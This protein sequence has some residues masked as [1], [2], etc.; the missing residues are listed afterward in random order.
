MFK[1]LCGWTDGEKNFLPWM[2]QLKR[3]H[4]Q[5][6]VHRLVWML[7][8]YNSYIMKQQW[9]ISWILTVQLLSLLQSKRLVCVLISRLVTEI[10]V[11]FIRMG[12]CLCVLKFTTSL[13][14]IQHLVKSSYLSG[15]DMKYDLLSLSAI[16]KFLVM[17]DFLVDCSVVEEHFQNLEMN[18]L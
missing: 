1:L 14:R 18:I 12:F 8:R 10:F 7:I 17:V 15:P 6:S 4:I 9:M 5:T 2:S 16:V 3:F 13:D 11:D